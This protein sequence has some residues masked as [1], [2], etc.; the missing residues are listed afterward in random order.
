MKTKSGI[1]VDV[2]EYRDEVGL[3]VQH[4][5]G[6]SGARDVAVLMTVAH[7]LCHPWDVVAAGT[8]I[9]IF[10]AR[11]GW[12]L[13]L[14]PVGAQRV[15]AGLKPISSVLT[16][17]EVRTV[18]ELLRSAA[19]WALHPPRLTVVAIGGFGL[20]NPTE[21]LRGVIRH[22][23]DGLPDMLRGEVDRVLAHEE[24]VGER[25]LVTRK[26]LAALRAADPVPSS[27][28]H[29]MRWARRS[30]LWRVKRQCPEVWEPCA[31]DAAGAVMVVLP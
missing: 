3:S 29:D 17:D 10:G 12:R 22:L 20:T 13:P 1:Y 26:S 27:E 6:A 23:N 31:P 15:A 28:G 14:R 19:K 11:P 18:R 21:L 7:G 30:D 25:S 5:V 9:P 8:P 4:E 24:K 2:S 16:S